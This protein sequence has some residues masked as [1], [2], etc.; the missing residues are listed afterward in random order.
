VENIKMQTLSWEAQE[1]SKTQ[2][3]SKN[4]LFDL[5]D[6]FCQ[7]EEEDLRPPLPN[8]LLLRGI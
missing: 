3:N 8:H 6:C 1:H 4:S 2:K 5:R 7:E